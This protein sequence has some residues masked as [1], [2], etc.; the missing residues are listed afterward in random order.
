[1]WRLRVGATTTDNEI[2]YSPNPLQ[3]PQLQQFGI[4]ALLG[5]PLGY[6]GYQYRQRETQPQQRDE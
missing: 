5:G 2:H 3:K 4:T 6:G 1:V